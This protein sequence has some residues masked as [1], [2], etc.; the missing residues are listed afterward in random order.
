MSDS[1]EKTGIPRRRFLIGAAATAMAAADLFPLVRIGRAAPIE[2]PPLPYPENALEPAVS[3]RTIG[4]HYGKHHKGYVEKLNDLVAGTPLADSDLESIVVACASDPEKAAIYNNAAQVWNHTFYWRSLRPNGG[5]KPS[6]DLAGRIDA[7]FGSFE[8]MKKHLSEAAAGQFGSGWAWLVAEKDALK[9][10][11]TSNA[12]TPIA[13]G[14]VPL[15]AIDVWEHAYYLDYQ[16]RRKDYIAAVID[17]LMNWDFASEN[18][19]RL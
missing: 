16:N 2:L 12:A 10:I 19:A 1:E 6:G 15:L 9:V 7:S 3:A 8:E 5:G 17:G 11:K 18:L 13:S 4:F 14:L